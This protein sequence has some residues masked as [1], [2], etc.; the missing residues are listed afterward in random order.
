MDL[1]TLRDIIEKDEGKIFVYEEGKPLL[2]L[3]NFDVY[4][5]LVNKNFKEDEKEKPAGKSIVDLITRKEEKPEKPEIQEE[6]NETGEDLDI[7]DLNL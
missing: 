1:K 4:K 3:M 5:K 2:V 6:T 7:D